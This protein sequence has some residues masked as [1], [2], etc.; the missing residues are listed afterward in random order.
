MTHHT[1]YTNN[2]EYKRGVY[3]AVHFGTYDNNRPHGPEYD[4]GFMAAYFERFG[5]AYEGKTY[6]QVQAEKE[7]QQAQDEFREK[8]EVHRTFLGS[9]NFGD[10]LFARLCAMLVEL[11]RAAF[12]M[13]IQSNAQNAQDIFGTVNDFTMNVAKILKA[14]V[15]V[16]CIWLVLF[17]HN[18]FE[19]NDGIKY[20]QGSSSFQKQEQVSNSQTQPQASTPAPIAKSQEIQAEFDGENDSMTSQNYKDTSNLN[21]K[22]NKFVNEA[23]AKIERNW[24]VPIEASNMGIDKIYAEVLFKV[25]RNGYLPENPTIIKSSGLKSI[26]DACIEAIGHST[27]FIG[28]PPEYDKDFIEIKFTFDANRR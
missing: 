19:S 18:G 28:Y 23:S 6:S 5:R 25:G 9:V 13:L 7:A 4:A 8:C 12:M 2:I 20:N 27:P 14:L 3:D 10:T 17:I 11:L 1:S 24:K 15:V 16:G 21:I 22:L 26:D